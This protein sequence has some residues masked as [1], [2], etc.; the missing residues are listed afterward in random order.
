[1]M[2]SRERRCDADVSKFTLRVENFDLQCPECEQ[3]IEKPEQAFEQMGEIVIVYLCDSCRNE[4]TDY[5]EF[6]RRSV[7]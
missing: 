1:M 7:E 3:P 2:M 6:S 4:T 5:Y